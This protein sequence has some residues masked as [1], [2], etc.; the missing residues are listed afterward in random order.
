MSSPANG[1]GAGLGAR[2]A[3]Q[4]LSSGETPAGQRTSTW[5]RALP[6][7]GRPSGDGA[8]DQRRSGFAPVGVPKRA[9][10]GSAAIAVSGPRGWPPVSAVARAVGA[11]LAAGAVNMPVLAATH[12]DCVAQSASAPVVASMAT[13]ATSSKPVSRGVTTPVTGSTATSEAAVGEA[14]RSPIQRWPA[15]SQARL[16]GVPATVATKSGW[17]GCARSNANTVAV[18]GAP[19]PVTK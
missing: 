4:T 19:S 1:I 11:P 17:T 2:L 13:P 18:T 15:A 7:S 12:D 5:N 16:V 6:A 10:S 14:G 9:G 3:F 8:R